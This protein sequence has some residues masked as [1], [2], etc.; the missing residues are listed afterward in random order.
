MPAKVL[1]YDEEARRALERGVEKVASAV[2]VTLGPKGR[3]VVL[4]KKWGSPTITKDGVTVAKE[5]ELEDPIENLGAQLVKEVASKTNDMAGD[6]TTTAT[7]LAWSIVHEG[8]RNVAAGAN[9]MLIKRG[10]DRAVE[11]VVDELKK[12]SISVEGKRDIAQVAGIA[13]NDTEVGDTIADAMDKVGKDGV[14]TIEEGKGIETAVEVV[15]GMQF[16]RGYISAYFITDPDKMEVL[17]EEPY[18]LLTEKKI[19][20]A[21]DIVPLMEKVIRLGKPLVVVAEDIEGEALATLVVNKLRGI[22]NSAAVKAPGYGDRRKAMLQDM[23][24]LTGGR[25]ISDDIGMKLESVELDMLGRADKVKADKDD[26]VIIGGKG[27]RKEIQGRIAQIKKEIEDTTSDYDKEKLQERLAKLSGGVAEIKVGAATETEMKEK[28]HRFEDALN[29]TKAAVE[30]GIVPGGGAAFIRALAALEKLEAE[31]DEAV[32]VALVRR[33]LEEP[34]RQL[35]ANAGVEGS[36]IVERLKRESGRTGYDVAKGEFTDMM[37]AGIVDP[38]KVAR[39]ALQN[40]ASVA[41]LMLTTEAVVV[42]KREKKKA[43]PPMPGGGMGD[44]DF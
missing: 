10:I 41:G 39:L 37:K 11:T 7:V 22:L 4:E 40:A 35:A 15:E 25:V 12:S 18:I 33:A 44:E 42:E 5:I 2:R 38:T 34:A 9:P 1:L 17:V 29:A 23:A 16:D 8:L 30:E 27:E 26:T 6:G 28:K 43:A 36:L 13:A 32:G 24:V 19:S 21:R 20:A 31:G 14:I 3:N